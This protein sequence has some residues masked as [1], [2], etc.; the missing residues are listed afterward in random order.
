MHC[1]RTHIDHQEW[2]WNGLIMS[3]WNGTYSTAEAIKAGLDLEM[4]YVNVYFSLSHPLLYWIV[5]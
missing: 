2:G 5:D 4:P 1:C 3:D